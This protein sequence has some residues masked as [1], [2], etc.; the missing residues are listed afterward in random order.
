[1]RQVSQVRHECAKNENTK[2]S[3]ISMYRKLYGRFE[4]LRGHKN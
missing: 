3:N 1:M 2:Y 4:S